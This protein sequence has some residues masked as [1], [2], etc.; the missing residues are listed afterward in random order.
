MVFPPNISN[1]TKVCVNGIEISKV[2]SCRYL[3]VV[4]DEELKWTSHIKSVC[5]E[6]L[7]Y[8]GIFYKPRDKLPVKILREMYYASAHPL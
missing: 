4:I 2:A 8:T 1:G 5:N 6:L 3:D 7:K